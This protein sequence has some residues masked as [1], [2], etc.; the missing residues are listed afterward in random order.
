M[1]SQTIASFRK[2]FLCTNLKDM[3]NLVISY[4]YYHNNMFVRKVL[5]KIMRM[6]ESMIGMA[7]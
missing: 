1:T 6:E 5:K 7:R 3:F 2:S 4:V